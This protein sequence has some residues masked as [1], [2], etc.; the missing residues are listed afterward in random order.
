MQQIPHSYPDA[1]VTPMQQIPHSY[2]DATDATR[3]DALK[4][5]DG[6]FLMQG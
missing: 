5:L 3:A 6:L 2:P 4:I 1:T